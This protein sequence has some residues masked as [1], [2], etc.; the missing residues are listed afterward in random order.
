MTDEKY[1]RMHGGECI[2]CEILSACYLFKCKE[3]QKEYLACEKCGDTSTTE[4]NSCYY[5]RPTISDELR[6]IVYKMYDI[7]TTLKL[8]VK[9]KCIRRVFGKKDEM[10][11]ESCILFDYNSN[12]KR[13]IDK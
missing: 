3:C 6:S 13:K 11:C 5:C 10:A 1:K 9:C 12:K 8:C 4:S 7:R 2:Y